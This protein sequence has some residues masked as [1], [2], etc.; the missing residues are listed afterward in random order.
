MKVHVDY[1][2]FQLS[3]VYTPHPTNLWGSDK[4]AAQTKYRTL[5]RSQVKRGQILPSPEHIKRALLVRKVHSHGRVK[6]RWTAGTFS[7][8]SLCGRS[9]KR[10]IRFCSSHL[11][12]R[13]PI[14]LH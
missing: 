13:S 12:E 9:E 5:K 10:E 11:Q 4:V 6:Q 2:L 1:W 8:Q 14:K 7:Q 3:C